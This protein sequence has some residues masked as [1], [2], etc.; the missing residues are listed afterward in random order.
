MPNYIN[1]AMLHPKGFDEAIE[2]PYGLRA[3]EIKA[4]V[5][6]IYDFLHAMN[7]FLVEHGWDRLE[8]TLSA[9]TFS[10]VISELFVAGVSKRSATIIANQYHNGRPD[11]VPRGSYPDDKAQRGVDGIEVKASRRSAGWQGHNKESGWLMMC[12]YSVDIATEPPTERQPTRVVRV[13]CARL[14]ES[15]WSFSGRGEGSRRTPTA[16]ISRTKLVAS[17]VYLDPA[18]GE[19]SSRKKPP[20]KPPPA[21]PNAAPPAPR[22]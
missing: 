22:A 19:G 13:L 17:V 4:A 6:D 15:D 18:Y 1:R 12:Q 5:D 11:L 14:D 10:G 16:T 21:A 7:K 20:A 8:E 3:S 9:A 2:L